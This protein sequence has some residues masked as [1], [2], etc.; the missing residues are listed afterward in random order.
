M[1]KAV[2]L[3]VLLILL[4]GCTTVVKDKKVDVE[5]NK[6]IKKEIILEEEPVEELEDK[7]SVPNVK[8]NNTLITLNKTEC[9][10]DCP[11]F[12]ISISKDSVLTFKGIKYV[13]VIGQKEIKL[14]DKQYSS[15]ET[16]IDSSKFK[17]LDNKYLGN[18]DK[19][20]SNT[21]ITYD[22][23]SVTVRLWKNAPKKFTNLY[24]LLEDILYDNKF[25][26]E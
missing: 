8:V 21:I 11:V 24:V 19:D 23:K 7:S 15:I 9:S 18:G 16:G 2:F 3:S 1:K 14:T 4:V 22:G 13:S 25:L 10:G 12:E 26:E 20:F 6:E 5:E 17:Q